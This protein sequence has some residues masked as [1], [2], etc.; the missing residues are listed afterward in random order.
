MRFRGDLEPSTHVLQDYNLGE[1]NV[2]LYLFIYIYVY[3]DIYLAASRLGK[4]PPLF[5]STS[6]N[7]YCCT[8]LTIILRGRAGA[9]FSKVP[10]LFG[11]ISGAAIPFISLQRQGSKQSNFA[12]LL[13]FLTSKHV[14]RSAFQDKRIPV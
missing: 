7:N 11:P 12:I 2:G 13:V 3:V 4:Y 6:V 8:Y 14:R 10:K 9:C 1:K 5:T